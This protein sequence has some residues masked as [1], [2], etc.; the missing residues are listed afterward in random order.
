MGWITEE[1]K[2]KALEYKYHNDDSGWSLIGVKV[3]NDPLSDVVSKA[4]YSTVTVNLAFKR[5]HQYYTLTLIVPII[6]LTILTPIGL[7][8]PG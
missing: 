2:L 4:N 3:T 1:S 8:L 6:V 7:F 5:N